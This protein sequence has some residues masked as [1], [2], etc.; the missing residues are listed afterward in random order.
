MLLFRYYGLVAQRF[1]CLNREY[2]ALFEECFTKQY[3]LIHRLETN[4]LRNVARMFAHLLSTD[5]VSWAILQVIR[6]T[7]DDTTSS[8]RI[9]I[10]ILF[11]VSSGTGIHAPL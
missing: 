6:V 2:Q 11:Q 7:E 10:K 3:M 1:C 4:K 8:S 5:A 9:F